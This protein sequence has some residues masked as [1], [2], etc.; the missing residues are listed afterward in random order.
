M[1]SKRSRLA[2]MGVLALATSVTLSLASGSVADAK[3][4]GS[5]SAVVST[6]V[7]A[8]IPDRAVGGTANFGQLVVPLKVGKKFKGKKVGADGVSVTFQTT[9]DALNAASDLRIYLVAPKGRL[10][11]LN[12]DVGSFYNGESIGPL[13]LT[14]NSSVGICGSATPPCPDPLATLNRPFVGTAEDSY[15]SVFHGMQVQGTWKLIFQDTSNTKTS[16]VHTVKLSIA[17][18]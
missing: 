6:N 9:G 17:A 12:T 18:A 10:S 11:L 15:L 13:T 3:S 14:P 8:A 16:T 5:K 7:N 2:L 1:K 4:K